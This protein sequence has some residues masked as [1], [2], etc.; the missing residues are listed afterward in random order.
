MKN[1]MKAHERL[2]SL[3]RGNGF[4]RLPMIE[5]TPWWEPTLERWRGEGLPGN[6]DCRGIQL[7]LGLDACV[8]SW[9]QART[10]E[11]PNAPRR[12]LGI[13]NRE[14]GYGDIEKTLYPE[15]SG[16]FSPEYLGWLKK[17]REEGNTIHGLTLEG[18]FW[19]PR[20]ILGI[21]RHLLSFYDEP[22]LL[23]EICA[24]Y[25]S[26]LEKALEYIGNTFQFDFMTFAEDM[27]Y[28]N[29]P[30]IGKGI[31]DEYLA[32]YYRR[33]IPLVKKLDIPVFIDSDGDITLALEWYA[34]VGTEGMLPLERQAGADAALYVE[35]KPWL[36]FIGNFDKT[37]MKFGEEAMRKEFERLLPV[38]KKGNLIPSVD[39][40]TPP[41]VSL[42]NYRI[43]MDLFK[44]YAAMVSR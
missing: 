44:E 11:T 26:W 22:D 24:R 38:C 36:T 10:R 27:S 28:K 5:W 23:S 37:C 2:R 42:E 41:D 8:R 21:E 31:F 7:Y 25:L 12:G 32:P 29:G 33:I 14:T 1:E 9:V 39:H 20:E 35:K 18:F 43:Y 40:K 3:I 19:F 16:Y 30:M 34:E 4:D 13:L 15:P 6:L 17:T